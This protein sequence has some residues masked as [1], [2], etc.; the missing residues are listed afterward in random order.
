MT[1]L[2]KVQ[3]FINSLDLNS[4][5]QYIALYIGTLLLLMGTIFFFY[6]RSANRWINTLSDINAQREKARMILQKAAQVYSYRAEVNRM[7]QQ[8]PDFKIAGYLQEIMGTVGIAFTDIKTTQVDR[9]DNYQETLA[10]I[11]FAST[12][13]KKLIEFLDVIYKNKRLHTKDLDIIRSKKVPRTIDVTVVIATM[14]PRQTSGTG[15][16]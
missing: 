7:I 3:D 8:D 5:Y 1:V 15:G 10:T 12:T 13:M 6:Y 2:E 14:Q 9:E 16:G 11:T 4:W